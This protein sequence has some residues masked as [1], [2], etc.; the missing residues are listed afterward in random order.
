MLNA[1]RELSLR[2]QSFHFLLLNAFEGVRLWC[3]RSLAAHHR[4]M[5]LCVSPF[6]LKAAVDERVL[7]EKQRS[8]RAKCPR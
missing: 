3:V 5:G 6:V 2:L 1:L 8:L 7:R 4:G